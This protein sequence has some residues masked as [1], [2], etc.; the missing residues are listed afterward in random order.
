MFF[1]KFWP[2]D[3]KKSFAFA[4]FEKCMVEMFGY[5]FMFANGI[6]FKKQF[7][8]IFFF[9]LLGEKNQTKVCILQQ[10]LI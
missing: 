6:P 5:A 7:F 1:G 9:F 8:S 10:D 2:F 3:N 4:I